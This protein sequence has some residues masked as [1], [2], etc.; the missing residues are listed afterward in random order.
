MNYIRLNML[1][2]VSSLSMLASMPPS[3]PLSPKICPTVKET[4]VVILQALYPHLCENQESDDE[5]SQDEYIITVTKPSLNSLYG[6][7]L[8]S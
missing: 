2:I 8:R 3:P 5:S 1:S 4:P 6:Y 7:L